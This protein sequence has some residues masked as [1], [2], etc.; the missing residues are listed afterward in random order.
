MTMTIAIVALSRSPG[1]ALDFEEPAIDGNVSS[2][3]TA[4]V[5]NIESKQWAEVFLPGIRMDG[6]N[7][8]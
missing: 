4:D 8:G 1:K 3:D 5:H 2:H 7:Q 6:T